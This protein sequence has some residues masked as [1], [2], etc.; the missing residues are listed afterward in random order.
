VEI[1]STSWTWWP[2]CPPRPL[3]LVRGRLCSSWHTERVGSSV[4][5][6]GLFMLLHNLAINFVC[7]M[8]ADKGHGLEKGSHLS[9]GLMRAHGASR[10]GV[11]VD[12]SK[13][14]QGT[15][16]SRHNKHKGERESGRKVSLC[17]NDPTRAY[18]HTREDCREQNAASK[19]SRNGR[20]DDKAITAIFVSTTICQ[21]TFGRGNG[22]C[23]MQSGTMLLIQTSGAPCEENLGVYAYNHRRHPNKSTNNGTLPRSAHMLTFCRILPTS[24]VVDQSSGCSRQC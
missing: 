16:G 20:V 19:K 6:F 22:N 12:T 2:S 1:P 9:M 8:P 3:T 21:F 17:I 18:A 7:A 11:P 10:G 23:T 5:L 24:L 4:W 13:R 14:P 15:K